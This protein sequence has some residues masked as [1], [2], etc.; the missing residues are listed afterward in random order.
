MQLY[1]D[2][3]DVKLT[4][5]T[6]IFRKHWEDTAE[7]NDGLREIILHRKAEAASMQRSNMGGW[8]SSHDLMTWQY[9]EI[10]KLGG[11]LNEAFGAVMER[12]LGH[13]AFDCRMSV[14]AWANVNESGNYNR[15]HTHANQHW[16]AVYYVDTGNPD[17]GVRPNGAIEFLDPRPAMGVF[18]IEPAIAVSTWTVEPKAG[19]MLMFPSW[20]RHGVLP[21]VGS[22]TR[23]SIAFNLRVADF[24]LRASL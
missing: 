9:P 18:E 14:T 22:G 20:L 2:G 24:K 21:Y 8:Q 11:F 23:I 1:D 17:P 3:S 12:E 4:F 16:S 7:L 13:R 19:D 10:Q 15:H 5:A 6:P